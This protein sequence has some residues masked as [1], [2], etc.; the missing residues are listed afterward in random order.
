MHVTGNAYTVFNSERCIWWLHVTARGNAGHGSRFVQ[1][2][3]TPK[4]IACVNKFLAYRQE[5]QELLESDHREGCSHANAAKRERKLGDVTTLNLTA[6]RA[7]HSDGAG[8]WLLNVIPT[9]AEAGF[10]IRSKLQLR[11]RASQ[12]RNTLAHLHTNHSLSLTHTS[13]MLHRTSAHT[14]PPTVDLEKFENDVIRSFTNIDGVTYDFHYKVTDQ[15][16]SSTDPQKSSYYRVFREVVD[17]FGKEV[18]IETFPAST[19]A[20]YL[21]ALNVEAIGFSPMHNT[22]ILLHDH[23]ERIQR[24]VYLEGVKLYEKLISKLATDS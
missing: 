11:S 3:A 19:D 16:I 10:D 20:R 7:G 9:E 6:L 15:S 17:T 13:H 18:E 1:D 21:R 8:K 23:D 4:L 2:T 24:S 12:H 5:Q 22:P 14:V